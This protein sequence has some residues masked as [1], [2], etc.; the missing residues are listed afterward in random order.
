MK[1]IIY[2]ISIISAVFGVACVAVAQIPTNNN[3]NAEQG[4]AIAAN[5]I[6]VCPPGPRD[7]IARCHA[8]VVVDSQGKPQTTSSPAAYGPVQLRT[9]YSLTG[10]GSPSQVIAIV[11]AYD[12]PNIKNDLDTYSAQYGL[13]ILPV[14]SGP[15]STSPI[16]CFAK[17]DQNGGTSYPGVNSG[18][19]LEISLD[20]EI[21]HAICPNCSILLVEADSSSL[22]D[23]FTAVDQAVTQGAT[24]VS[25][26]YGTSG[27]FSGETSY[28][29]HFDHPGIAITVSAGDSGYGTSYPASSSYVTA[30]GGTSLYL[31]PNNTYNSESVW[32]RTGGGCSSQES[33][34]PQGQ[35]TISGCT[36]R[37][38]S[39]VSADADPSTGAAVYDSVPYSGQTGWFK[40]GG[41]SLSSPLVAAV[42]ALAGGVPA[43][44][45]GNSIPY[46]QKN[47]STNTHD[48]TSGTNGR[49]RRGVTL[50]SALIGYDSPSGIGTP[51]GVGAF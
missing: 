5:N 44:V 28:D 42:Y 36:R 41:T 25:N 39:D 38:I 33:L 1:K 40:V 20:V 50:C 6:P 49:C 7:D 19:A 35:P 14:C 3:A 23:L 10:T 26:S 45:Q 22:T 43:S 11:D 30:V 48:V 16:A 46:S 4:I 18:W 12:H 32:N 29:S 15:I 34:K 24:E 2:S 31:N 9:G 51:N 37:I 17:L 8:R 13:P 21:A 27:E 47:Y